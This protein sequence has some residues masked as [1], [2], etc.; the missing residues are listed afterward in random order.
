[1]VESLFSALC[2]KLPTMTK[3][4][5]P[6][7]DS[8]LIKSL[9]QPSASL[10]GELAVFRSPGAGFRERAASRPIYWGRSHE[11]YKKD[12]NRTHKFRARDWGVSGPLDQLETFPVVDPP[13]ASTRLG[14]TSSHHSA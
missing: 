7:F 14:A 5:T 12:Q 6:V 9:C 8:V 13:H 10:D 4:M 1:M 3:L 2:L 11:R